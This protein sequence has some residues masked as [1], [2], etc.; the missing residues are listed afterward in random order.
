MVAY[1]SDHQRRGV[2]AATAGMQKCSER[3]TET[4]S[5]ISGL[6]DR[7]LEAAGGGEAEANAA[8]VAD[9]LADRLTEL[10]DEEKEVRE[11]MV[12]I[13]ADLNTA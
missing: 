1:I 7:G 10:M 5:E 2:S 11:E 6:T 3:L 9:A 13:A 4:T 12:S 8:S